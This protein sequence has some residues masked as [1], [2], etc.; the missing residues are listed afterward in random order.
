MPV[1]NVSYSPE[2]NPIEAV[3]S[4]VKRL[5]THS[6]L[7]H[8]VNKTGF[9]ADKEIKDAFKAIT[10]DHCSV[11]V[12]KSYHLLERACEVYEAYEV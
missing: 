8:L 3:F 7:N 11:C 10:A 1:Y 9:N 12:R 4:K 5:F 6:R 2:Y